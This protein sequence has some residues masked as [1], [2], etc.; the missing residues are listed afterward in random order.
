MVANNQIEYK[1]KLTD[2]LEK[3]L[4]L[5][6]GFARSLELLTEDGSFN[7]AAYLLSDENGCSI[8]VAKYS[9]TDRVDLIENEEFGYCSLIK[10]TK[11]V[12][13]KLKIEP[14]QRSRE[15]ENRQG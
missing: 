6:Y 14:S 4:T 3:G 2:G 12:E 15:S 5:N 1:A 7:Y 9:G 8:K 10:A 13:G 11:S